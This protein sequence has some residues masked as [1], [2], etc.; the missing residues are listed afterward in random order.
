ML[1]TLKMKYG[2]PNIES[3][4]NIV[5]I[6]KNQRISLEWTYRYDKDAMGWINFDVRTALVY[7]KIDVHSAD[8]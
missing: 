7:E 8:F 3:K 5:W 1:G 6:K 2:K 4:N